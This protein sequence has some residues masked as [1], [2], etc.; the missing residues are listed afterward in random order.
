VKLKYIIALIVLML[1]VVIMVQ[2]AQVVTL[3]F[4]FWKVSVS[5][6]VLLLFTLLI[7]FAW[8]FLTAKL[9]GRR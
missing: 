5:R 2:N 4:L 3:R 9:A 7:G 8:G 1:A 6:I